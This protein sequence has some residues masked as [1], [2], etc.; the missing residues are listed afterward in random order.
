MCGI[1]SKRTHQLSIIGDEK[2]LEIANLF[3]FVFLF[4]CDNL[5]C[6]S[7]TC[8]SGCLCLYILIFLCLCLCNFY[9]YL[10]QTIY[11]THLEL[12]DLGVK[13]E[14]VEEHRADERYMGRLAAWISLVK[15]RM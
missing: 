8:R 3:V 5:Q 15:I 13:G 14:G 12:A 2:Y 6:A 11:K 4:V 1:R 9:L 10:S 7:G